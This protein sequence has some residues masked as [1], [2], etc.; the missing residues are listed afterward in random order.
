M[1]QVGRAGDSGG[2]KRHR[3]DEIRLRE[4]RRRDRRARA[5]LV[6]VVREADRDAAVDRAGERAFER[7]RE[8]IGK[9][10]VV[11]R[12]VETLLRLREPVGEE[13]RGVFR[14]LAA[15]GKRVNVYRAAFA[16]SAALCARFAA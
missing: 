2:R 12:D 10:Q 5:V 7:A 14:R 16:R 3:R 4:R 8:R 15:V 1:H 9:T 13:A 6:E 11:D